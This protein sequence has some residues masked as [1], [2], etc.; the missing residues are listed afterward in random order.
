MAE[1]NNCTYNITVS[2]IQTLDTGISS[3]SRDRTVEHSNINTQKSLTGTSSSS[4]PAV[5]KMVW[6]NQALSGGAATL[7]LTALTGTN[8]ATVDFT[9]L[10]VCV[11]KFKNPSGN[12]A[13]TVKFGAAT[14]YNLGGASWTFIL[15]ADSEMTIYSNEGSPDVSGSAKHIDLSGTDSEV[16]EVQLFAG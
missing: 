16:L 7:D 8:G 4:Q 1:T 13:M 9:G 6:G 11:A 15:A 10:K 2:G 14:P 3:G 5:T 12:A